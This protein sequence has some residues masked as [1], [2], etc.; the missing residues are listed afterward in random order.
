MDPLPN[1]DD[2][3]LIGV[4]CCATF[5]AHDDPTTLGTRRKPDIRL[6]FQHEQSQINPGIPLHLEKDPVTVGLD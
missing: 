6:C 1:M 2:K 3:N 4:A 5:V